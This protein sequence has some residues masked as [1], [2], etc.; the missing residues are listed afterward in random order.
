MAFMKDISSATF[1]KHFYSPTDII[2]LFYA[3]LKLSNVAL[4]NNWL[5]Q[6]FQWKLI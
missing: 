4:I 3:V 6:C 2:I 5:F 1:T